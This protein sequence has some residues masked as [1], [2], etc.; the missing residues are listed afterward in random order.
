MTTPLG[1]TPF[2]S[3][4]VAV[5]NEAGFIGGLL[6]TIFAQ[7]YPADRFEVIVADGAST[8]DTRTVLAAAQN[9]EPRLSVVDN[10]KRIVSA[11]LNLAIEHAKGE[12]LIRV[13]GHAVIAPD[14][15]RQNVALLAAHP[16]AW[17]V[18]GPI[19]HDAK[20][21]FGKA[22]AVA[23]SHPIGV[24]NALHRYPDYEGYVEGAQFPAIRRWVFERIGTFDETL[25]RNQDDEFNY[26]I[27]QAGGL[28]YVSPRVRYLYFVRSRV[29]QLFRQYFQYGF[30]RIPV[31]EKHGRPTTVRQLAPTLFVVGCVLLAV[32]GAFWQRPGVAAALPTI[33]LGVLFAAAVHQAPRVTMKVALRIPVAMMTMHIAYGLGF[34]YGM[35]AKVFHVRA[36]DYQG[37]MAT[38]SR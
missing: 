4:I 26:R 3:V 5:R 7:D 23:M 28:V 30:W 20:T 16:E 14:F 29:G 21:T 31:V 32:G 2:V 6:D 34:G 33:Y 38:I 24:G 37:Q 13:D 36:W 35:W 11:G 18:G 25:V 27:H 17:S 22:V 8:D 9:I 19:R 10:P 15:I 1:S 12:V